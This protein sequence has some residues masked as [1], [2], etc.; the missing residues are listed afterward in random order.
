MKKTKNVKV[1][2]TLK[3]E[4]LIT[5]SPSLFLKSFKQFSLAFVGL[6][7]AISLSFL[8][9]SSFLNH[10]ALAANCGGA[11]V[12]SC[13]DTVTSDY[14]LPADLTCS[15]HGLVVGADDITI[16]GNGHKITINDTLRAYTG[17]LNNGFNNIT[18]QN[19]TIDGWAREG[20]FMGG[21]AGTHISNITL[22]NNTINNTRYAIHPQ[23]VDSGTFSG[24]TIY[25]ADSLGV[26]IVNANNINFTNNTFLYSARPFGAAGNN[27]TIDNNYFLK[28]RENMDT[29]FITSTITNNQIIDGAISKM[30]TWNEISRLLSKGDTVN[31]SF[32][33][34]DFYGAACPGCTYTATT[35]PTETVTDSAVGNNVT[36]SFVV[37]NSG[38]YSLE[39]TITDTQ[40]NY[41]KKNYMFLVDPTGSQTTRY[42]FTPDLTYHAQGAGTDAKAL[43]LTA[44][45]ADAEWQC[46]KWIGNSVDEIPDYPLAVVDRV[47]Y[48]VWYVD[49]PRPMTAAPGSGDPGVFGFDKLAGYDFNYDLP[50][51]GVY[52]VPFNRHADP[53]VALTPG[54]K[55]SKNFTGLN[56]PMDYLWSWYNMELKYVVKTYND[57]PVWQTFVSSPSYADFQYTYS[58]TPAIQSTSNSDISILAATQS[59]AADPN[60]ASVIL[61]G[62]GSAN[63]T[64]D[65]FDKPFIGYN[66]RI[67]SSGTTT[68]NLTGL[69]GVT[70]INNVADMSIT[71]SAGYIDV[72]IDT[73]NTSGTYYKKWTESGVPGALTSN[74]VINDLQPN[75]HYY[76]KI[77]GIVDSDYT[78]DGSGQITF[79]YTGGYSTKTFEITTTIS[80]GGGSNPSVTGF[81]ENVDFTINNGAEATNDPQVTLNINSQSAKEMLI[82]NDPNFIDAQWEPLASEK[83]WQL[84]PGLGT[85]TVYAY[86]RDENNNTSQLYTAQ[87]NLEETQELTQPEECQVPE[88]FQLPEGIEAGDLLKVQ[89]VTTV[90]FVSGC[91]LRRHPFPNE[92]TYFTWYPDFQ[93]I[94]LIDADIISQIPLGENIT[95]RPGTALVKTY[96]MSQVYA[97]EPEETLREIPTAEIAAKLYGPNWAD[98]LVDIPDAFFI[99]YIVGEKITEIKYPTASV[100][101]Y[102]NSQDIYYIEDDLKRLITPEVFKTDLFLNKFIITDVSNDFVYETG[103]NWPV[104]EIGRLLTY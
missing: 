60:T 64:L 102:Q 1:R 26:W 101:Q 77:N 98:L 28:G 22:L 65:N 94:K 78:S 32:A 49:Y 96:T 20:I 7:S 51:A 66:S 87:I 68:V 75:T 103:D 104:Q 91:D 29:G 50:A 5:S 19:L 62:T 92:T 30:I 10:Q 18:I 33:M 57:G 54:I 71:P 58:T 89:D 3:K 37:N 41:F 43:R 67:D 83:S 39:I 27:W 44:P 95:V 70:T 63:L 23:Y 8:L 35:Y 42:Y 13:G 55:L 47:D 31:F 80:S 82:S 48:E 100:V 86:F 6:C 21:T 25:N 81:T 59:D 76:L 45:I 97:V 52:D 40:G 85:K 46:D 69:S 93:N 34:N 56:I 84:L 61:S 74:H 9:S 16:D 72:N 12:C 17:I 99:D 4:K 53:F 73:W 88:G 11:V 79:N 90:Y 36:G 24:N 14:T 38:T 2:K 15:S